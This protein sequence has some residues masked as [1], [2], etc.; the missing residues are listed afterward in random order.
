M[1]P[2][3]NAQTGNQL[4]A[5]VIPAWNRRDDVLRLL[6]S[7]ARQTTP[8]GAIVVVDNASND[9]TA[10]AVAT[11]FPGVTVLRQEENLGGAGGFNAGMAWAIENVFDHAWL[12]D[13]DTLAEPTALAELLAAMEE[14][15]AAEVGSAT[16]HEGADEVQEAGGQI[17]SCTGELILL[18]RG[19]HPDRLPREPYDA[20]YV[21]ACSALVK[22]AAVKECGS[23]RN[24]YFVFYDDI[25]LSCRLRRAGRRVV[26]APR[27][28]VHHR[29]HG[30]KPKAPWRLYYAL[31]NSIDCFLRHGRPLRRFC[32]AVRQFTGAERLARSYEAAGAH[33]SAEACRL[34]IEH[35]RDGVLGRIDTPW[36]DDAGAPATGRA[37]IVGPFLRGVCNAVR[38]KRRKPEL[39]DHAEEPK[40][41]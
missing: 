9:D 28:R 16:I 37:S 40:G 39:L 18:H 1:R 22:L 27:S 4:T 2:L 21:A 26:V 25:E 10:D 29:F 32:V 30:D 7:V 15:G 3:Q 5:A 20:D 19:E 14:T 11:A 13:S 31:R 23:M 38:A 35:A 36:G 17:N 24:D 34:A 33:E 12:L 8:P 41:A 6:D